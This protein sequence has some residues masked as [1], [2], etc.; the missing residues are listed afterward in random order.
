MNNPEVNN[1][2]LPPALV[3]PPTDGKLSCE[4]WALSYFAS[5]DSAKKK[6]EQLNQRVDA[7]KRYGDHVG[8]IDLLQA[9]GLISLPNGKG[10][11]DLHEELEASFTGRVKR[12]IPL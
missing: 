10:H 1:N 5:F 8:E 9:D 3:S 4:H 2:F 7:K 12:F 11:F 6:F